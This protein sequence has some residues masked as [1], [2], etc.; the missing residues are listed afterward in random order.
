[1][2]AATMLVRIRRRVRSVSSGSSAIT[3]AMTQRYGRERETTTR[4]ET[5]R[6]QTALSGYVARLYADSA[7]VIE[8]GADSRAGVYGP[9]FA[10]QHLL[11]RAQRNE[12]VLPACRVAHRPDS[13]D[14]ALQRTECRADLDAEVF[15]QRTAY[16]RVVDAVRNDDRREH[17]KAALGRL[18]TE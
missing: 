12:H 2:S 15:E 16:A 18:L 3:S 7:V 11:Q 10:P 14:L 4:V 8:R 6:T 17:R 9:P 13:P 5:A 1:M